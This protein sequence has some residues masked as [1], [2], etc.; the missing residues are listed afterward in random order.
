[1]D[2]SVLSGPGPAGACKNRTQE[3][4]L[5]DSGNYFLT[6]VA[7]DVQH[8]WIRKSDVSG[9][10]EIAV[11]NLNKTGTPE[12]PVGLLVVHHDS[13]ADFVRADGEWKSGNPA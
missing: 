11:F 12:Q 8:I 7:A 1:M 10:E 3:S 4:G 2:H 5:A 9:S 6:P 13:G